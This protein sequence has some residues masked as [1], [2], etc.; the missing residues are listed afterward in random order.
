MV[1]VCSGNGIDVCVLAV[2]GVDDALLP[3]VH[4]TA[5][6]DTTRIKIPGTR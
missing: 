3:G 2:V 4:A 6:T 1:E 5:R